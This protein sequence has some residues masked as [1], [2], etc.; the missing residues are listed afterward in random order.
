[1][2]PPVPRLIIAL[3][4]GAKTSALATALGHTLREPGFYYSLAYTAAIVAL[5]SE[6]STALGPPVAVGGASTSRQ[7]RW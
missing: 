2:V 4:L 5:S 3:L 1:M 6:R 7:A